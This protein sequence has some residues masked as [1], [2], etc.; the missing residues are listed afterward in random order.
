L[1]EIETVLATR[2]P[3]YRA[4]ATFEVDTEGKEPREIVGEILDR[5]G[6]GP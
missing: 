3:I 4:C 6:M 1:G 5:L 2:E